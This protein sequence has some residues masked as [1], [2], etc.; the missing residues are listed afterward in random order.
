MVGLEILSYGLL[1][2]YICCLTIL[3][4][5]A[6][7]GFFLF[8]LSKR[9][10]KNL[11]TIPP[12]RLSENLPTVTVQLPVYNEKYVVRRLLD[13]ILK[14][15]YPQNR[16]QIQILDDSTDST[17]DIIRE[18]LSELKSTDFEI[19]HIH[20]NH[21]NGFKSGALRE[22][23]KTARGEFVAIFDSD[24]LPPSDFLLRSLPYFTST[25]IGLVQTRWSHL[26]EHFSSLTK[27]QAI[28]LNGHFLIE[29]AARNQNNYFINFNGTAGIW[30][31]S[32]IIDA[33][34]W[35]DDTL[36]EDLDLSYRAQMKGWEFV[37][38]PDILCPSELPPDVGSWKTQQYRWA[39][40]AVETCKKLLPEILKSSLP[41]RVK[42][43][44]FFHLTGNLVY[45][46]VL[47]SGVLLIP[48]VLI[49]NYYPVFSQIFMFMSLFLI[50]TIFSF[51]GFWYSQNRHEVGKI[52]RFKQF[53]QYLA[54]V[55]GISINNSKA[56]LSGLLNRKSEFVRTPKFH[57]FNHHRTIRKNSYQTG[58]SDFQGWFE[59]LLGFYCAAGCIVS[60]SLLEFA[61]LPFI[62]IYGAGFL[63][64]GM[65]SVPVLSRSFLRN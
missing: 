1:A 56:V 22:G 14:L 10:N 40:G 20:R 18:F 21:R 58:K 4:I 50:G 24:F 48:T 30:R 65:K 13:A 60:V 5:Y 39:K 45:P 55:T 38:R 8:I 27:T 31:K 57:I 12:Y 62:L 33:G 23:L 9:R 17:S 64:V 32:C 2:A 59:V 42:V 47:I 43:Q 26:N 46:L 11:T 16:L 15:E 29:Q 52:I 49:K 36:T 63:L 37:F 7:N 44:S 28:I 6:M 53:P 3:S 41:L 54:Y 35:Q 34:N 51:L 25:K 61:A 19:Q